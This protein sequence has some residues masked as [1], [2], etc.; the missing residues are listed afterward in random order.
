MKVLQALLLP[1]NIQDPPLLSGGA[2]AF[3]AVSKIS[4]KPV[5]CQW[6]LQIA[7]SGGSAIAYQNEL[8]AARPALH[9]WH[10]AR[11]TFVGKLST[12]RTCCSEET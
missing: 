2:E 7:V 12:D 8:L 1:D 4:V 5:W 11:S 9:Q 3:A 6:V 10:E